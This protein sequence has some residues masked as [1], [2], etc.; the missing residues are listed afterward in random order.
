MIPKTLT[1]LQSF[2][3]GHKVA[4][5]V[6]LTPATSASMNRPS[7]GKVNTKFLNRF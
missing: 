7:H 2:F 6:A 4:I 1:S 3:F 5:R